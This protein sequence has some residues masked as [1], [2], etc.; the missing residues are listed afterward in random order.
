VNLTLILVVGASAVLL[1]VLVSAI[2]TGEFRIEN[3]TTGFERRSISLLR[4]DDNPVVFWFLAAAH[5]AVI[6]YIASYAFV[7]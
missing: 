6:L 2:R 1:W 4:R 7:P 5:V 3:R